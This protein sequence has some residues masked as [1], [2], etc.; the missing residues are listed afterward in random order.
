MGSCHACEV[1]MNGEDVRSC[2]TAIP[3]DTPKITVHLF[4]DPSWG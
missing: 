1:E 4:S 3:A 2:I